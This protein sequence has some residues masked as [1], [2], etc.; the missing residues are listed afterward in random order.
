MSRKLVL[1]AA[2]IILLVGTLGFPSDFQRVEAS[3]TTYIRADG[4]IDGPANITTVDKVTYTFNESNC[5]TIVVERD[6][7]IIDGAGYTL[8]GTGVYLSNGIVL[9]GRTNVTIMNTQIKNFHSGLYLNSSSNNVITGNNMTANSEEGIRLE[10]SSNNSMTGN[11]LANNGVGIYLYESSSNNTISENTITANNWYGIVVTWSSNNSITGNNV[12]N[13]PFGITLYESSDNIVCGNT[14]DHDGLVVRFSCRNLVEDNTV[15]GKPLVYLEDVQNYTVGD[16]GQLILVKCKHITAEDLN[17][18]NTDVGLELSSASNCSITGNNVAN[19]LAGIILYERSSN[20][21]IAINDIRNNE[22]GMYL[23]GSSNNNSVVGNNVTANNSDGIYLECSSNN[24]ISGNR[25]A[26]NEYG[27]R[28]SE[29]SDNTF[30]HNNLIG[31]THQVYSYESASIWDDGYPFGGNYWSDYTGKDEYK[32]PDQNITG[33]D[34]IGDTAYVMVGNKDENNTDHYP[35]MGLFHSF[36]T[37]LGHVNVISNSTIDDFK[38]FE[39]NRTIRMYVSNMTVSQ[40][41]GFCRVCIPHTLMDVSNVSVIIDDGAVEVLHFND[42]IYDSGTHRWIYF[43]YQHSPLEIVIVQEFPSLII[44]PLFMI[45]TLL[46]VTL[47]RRKH[48]V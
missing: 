46:A 3:G 24:I 16:A 7:I 21:S 30:C 14:F 34:G 6:N 45:A 28:L 12:A 25:M 32:G 19:N 29:S 11:N 8:Q 1:L 43:A 47:Y 4:S 48:S 44:L 38:Y 20:N 31:N 35:L 27:F 18:S 39:M 13:N 10:F 40:T 9:S 15:N 41:F 26:N 36:N 22:Y 23:L 33:P 17:L 2:L 37:S 42:R 5:D